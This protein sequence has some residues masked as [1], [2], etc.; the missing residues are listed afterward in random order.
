M[1]ML[2]VVN[3]LVERTQQVRV[4]WKTAASRTSF[5]AVFG[6]LSVLISGHTTGMRNEIKLS[7]LDENGDEIERAESG[8]F[9]SDHQSVQLELLYQLA[10]RR[11]LGTDQRLEELMT[12]LDAAPPVSSS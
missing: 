10:K 3:K 6:N 1:E 9:S 4:P 11:V 5:L 2:E 8:G 7:V 12:R